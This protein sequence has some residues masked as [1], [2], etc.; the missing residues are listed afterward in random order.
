MGASCYCHKTHETHTD[1][2]PNLT[3]NKDRP[4]QHMILPIVQHNVSRA[5][6]SRRQQLIEAL[7][8]AEKFGDAV[9]ERKHSFAEI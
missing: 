9:A 3:L 6:V 5:L 1:F 7:V 2:K 8:T 4:R